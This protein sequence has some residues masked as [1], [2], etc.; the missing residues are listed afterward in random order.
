MVIRTPDKEGFLACHS[1]AHESSAQAEQ[2][3]TARV[4][5]AAATRCVRGVCVCVFGSRSE[6]AILT[7]M[8]LRR[9]RASLVV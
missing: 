3:S 2:V 5:N 8:R 6:L 9:W 1:P 7:S 4:F